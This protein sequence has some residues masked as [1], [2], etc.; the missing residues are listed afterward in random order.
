MIIKND[1]NSNINCLFSN[2]HHIK[3][4]EVE[5]SVWMQAA[6][7]NGVLRVPDL[8]QKPDLVTAE[9]QAVSAGIRSM[10]ISPLSV[11]RVR[12]VIWTW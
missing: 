3:L 10:L 1:C 9:Q 5:G 4:D 6:T 2:S 7:N 11:K 8:A 12:N